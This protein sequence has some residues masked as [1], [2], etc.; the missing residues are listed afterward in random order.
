[1][2][3]DT[4][5]QLALYEFI[6]QFVTDEK[7][8]KFQEILEMRTRH[9]TVVIEDVYQSQ[10]ASA[11]LRTCDCFGIQDVHIIE[12][13]NEF[14]F[15]KDVELGASKWLSIKKYNEK[16]ENTLDAYNHL[17]KQGYRIVA[18][19]PHKNEQTLDELPIDGK[20]ALVFGT[21]LNGLSDI[22]MEHAD[23]F[24]KIP[25][26]GFTES[27]NISVSAGIFLANLSRRIRKAELNWKLSEEEKTEVMFNWAKSVVKNP[28]SL[29]KAF[30]EKNVK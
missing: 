4:K 7:R 24:V 29:V 3:L 23:E 11:V 15:C 14:K 26:H 28:E 18:T 27:F 19:S 10:N 30:F 2:D 25:M 16:K 5:T 12:N 20:L 13:R 6:A 17:K 8:A 1:M 22:A 9:L 21:E